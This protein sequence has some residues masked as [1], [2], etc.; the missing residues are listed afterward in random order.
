MSIHL[1]DNMKRVLYPVRTKQSIIMEFFGLNDEDLGRNA[2]LVTKWVSQYYKFK[3]I[4][5]ARG[6]SESDM[7]EL[8]PHLPFDAIQEPSTTTPEVNGESGLPTVSGDTD[9][10]K[11]RGRKKSME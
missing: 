7:K 9:E 3:D 4:L 5:E 2:V 11:K 10:P 6:I 8:F 1:D